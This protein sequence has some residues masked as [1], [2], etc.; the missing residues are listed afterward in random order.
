MTMN[1]QKKA[2]ALKVK[3][4]LPEAFSPQRY[5]SREEYALAKDGKKIPISLVYKKDI[6]PKPSR[7]LLLYGY[8]AYGISMNPAFRPDIISLLDRGFIYA[9]AHVRGGSDKGKKWYEEGRLL[10]KKNT[11]SD[12]LFCARHLIDKNYSS[13]AHLYIMGG[14]AGGML[15]GAVLNE[16]PRL[17][18]G[19]VASVPFV[20]CLTSMLDENIPLSTGE[21][22]EWGN[23]NN[24]TYYD[25]IKSYSPYNNIRK[26]KYPP[27]LIQTG[28]NDP[29]VQYWEP[30]KWTARLRDRKTDS[31]PLL[32]LTNMKSGHFGS[33]GRLSALKL[34]SLY[35]AFFIGLEKGLI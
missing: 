15:I 25:Y 28:Y 2:C 22:E 20:D 14:S 4:L 32:L 7:P 18:K 17:F 10:K 9:I 33:S 26:T 12:F 16:N 31:N 13:P 8:G 3:F 34:Y 30:A 5:I 24:K 11:F 6:E 23:P 27:L 29:R 19:A 21:Y 1:R 35:Y